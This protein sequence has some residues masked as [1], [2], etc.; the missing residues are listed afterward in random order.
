MRVLF[1]LFTAVVLHSCSEANKNPQ[2]EKKIVPPQIE[3]IKKLSIRKVG[4]LGFR[5]S[6]SGSA[7]DNKWTN[8]WGYN[9]RDT[10][11]MKKFLEIGLVNNYGNLLLKKFDSCKVY[12]YYHRNVLFTLSDSLQKNL[13]VELCYTGGHNQF[14]LCAGDGE[15]TLEIEIDG[16]Y[17][18]GLKFIIADII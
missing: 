9:N 16:W 11:L 13:A 3:N 18:E 12:D 14:D 4:E 15:Q 1:F 7:P 2:V 10:L 6:Y 5:R 17:F 8:P